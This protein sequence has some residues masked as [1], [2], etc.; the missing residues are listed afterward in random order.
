MRKG[1]E[2]G[3]YPDQIKMIR[4]IVRFHHEWYAD[5]LEESS[6]EFLK[7]AI[8]DA[9]DGKNAKLFKFLIG[10]FKYVGG[11]DDI[12]D[13]VWE[14]MNPKPTYYGIKREL[15]SAKCPKLQSFSDFHGCGYSKN[16]QS[17][18]EPQSFNKCPLPQYN[19][20]NGKLNQ[21]VFSVYLFLRDRCNEDFPGFVKEILGSPRQVE[22]LNEDELKAAI[23]T[24]VGE[25]A[26]IFNVGR[27]LTNMTLSGLLYARNGNWNYSR[28]YPHMVAVDTLVHEFLHR[29]GTLKLFGREHKYGEACHSPEGCVGVI[30]DISR[31]IDCTRY[32]GEYPEYYPRMVQAC[33][34]KFCTDSCNRN[35]CKYDKLDNLCEFFDWCEHLS[36]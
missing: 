23:E 9:L 25:M 18:N 6:E 8:K 34:W 29:T 15:E 36:N 14:Q 1:N 12:A 7:P 35:E 24:L 3:E 30:N 21:M 19:M 4:C 31:Q 32:S 33:I 2:M 17:C 16:N 13:T 10:A 22:K 11:S 28:V 26:Q 27:K 5:L 20:R